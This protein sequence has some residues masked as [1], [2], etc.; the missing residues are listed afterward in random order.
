MNLSVESIKNLPKPLMASIAVTILSILGGGAVIFFLILPLH[1]S[2]G[3]VYSEVNEL[4]KTLATMKSD[5]KKL[6][7]LT[8]TGEQLTEERDAWVKTGTLKPEALS[9]SMRMG[10][11]ALMMPI[12]QKVDFKIDNVKESPTIL[13]RLPATVPEELY[14]RQPIEFVGQGSFEQITRFIQETE[15]KYPL[16]IL[17]GLVILSQQQTPACHKVVITFEWPVKQEWLPAGQK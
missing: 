16:T 13:L 9:N 4:E 17:S 11:K 12:A 1:V 8:K 14:A 5:I 6:D 2:K 10:A 7:E 15:E 3:A